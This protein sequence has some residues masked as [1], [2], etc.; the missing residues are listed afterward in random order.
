MNGMH[1]PW[2]HFITNN[3]LHS[4]RYSVNSEIQF[5]ANEANETY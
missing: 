1:V 5:V 3:I 2:K 4:I